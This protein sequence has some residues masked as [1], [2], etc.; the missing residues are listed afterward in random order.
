MKLLLPSDVGREALGSEWQFPKHLQAFQG[1]LADV[2]HDRIHRLIVSLPLR[3]GK[4]TF[5][6]LWA[7]WLLLV[8]PQARIL[9]VTYSATFSERGG[10]FV[11]TILNKLAWL[12]GLKLDPDCN[13]RSLV[14]TTA[15][16]CFACIGIG[17]N[18]G[19]ETF[20]WIL[21][22]D[23]LTTREEI[24]NAETRL[25][26]FQDWCAVMARQSV[27]RQVKIVMVGSRRCPDDPIGK[28]LDMNADLPAERRWSYFHFAALDEETD[29]ALWPEVWPV[30]RL[31]AERH[32]LELRAESWKWFSEWMNDP[33][34]DPGLAEWP[35][36]WFEGMLYG[37]LPPGTNIRLRIVACDPSKGAKSKLGDFC[38]M[39]S[40]ALDTAGTIWVEN[41]FM[42]PV[43]IPEVVAINIAE[44]VSYHPHAATVESE[45][46]DGKQDSAIGILICQALAARG[47][48]VPIYP[49]RPVENKSVRIRIGLSGWLRQHRVRVRDSMGG[50]LLVRQLQEFPSGNHDDGP[51]AATMGIALFDQLLGG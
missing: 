41:V 46:S 40:M 45:A 23:L 37:E 26:R 10:M 13:S 6:L 39:L 42:R 28:C 43:A 18:V 14:R 4:T 34:A 12:T 8:R 25:K 20:D 36:E 17:S 16:G 29:T 2:L 48:R 24:L 33:T 22:D 9:Y 1:R 15:G 19:G 21:S 44:I 38:A 30:A 5:L 31:K 35:R 49:Y 47:C 3:H 32:E 7:A 11:R 50:R 27:H 51:D